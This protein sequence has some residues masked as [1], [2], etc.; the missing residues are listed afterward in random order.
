MK[1]IEDLKIWVR[2]TGA[3]WLLLI[4]AWSG[5][6][7]WEDYSNRDTALNQAREFARSIHEMTMAGLTGMMITGTVAQREVFLDQI[8]Q[9]SI[10]RDLVV[11]RGEAVTKQF[12]AGTRKTPPMDAIEQEVMQSG[13]P[14]SAVHQDSGGDYLRVVTPALASKDYLGKNCTNC[15]LVAEKTPLGIVSMN[16]SLDRFDAE[17]I[18]NRLKSIAIALLLSIPFA[19]VVH[20][21]IRHS[22]TV[23]LEHMTD[24]LRDIARGEGDLT[25]RLEAGSADEI[26]M[27]ASVFNEMMAKIAGLVRQVSGS[28]RQ[29]LEAARAL[30]D[31]AA[32]VTAGSQHQSARAAATASTVAEMVASIASVATS[33]E[34]VHE[35]SQ[36]SRN[37]SRQGTDSLSQLIG[38]V[39]VV[40]AAV[41]DM[42]QAMNQFVQSTEAITA[43]TRDVKGIAEQTNLL[44]LNAAIEAARAGEQGRGFAVV[45]DE[46]R[47]LA[48]KSAHS[49]SEIEAITQ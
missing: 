45:A 4:A 35:R 27:A 24:G 17:V 3:I 37:R 26:G 1:K 15:H 13:K 14:Y 18:A 47:K 10:V 8:K 34:Q 28:A 38:E 41:K 6:L 48:E 9:L 2:L 39:G 42:A 21:F 19:F 46:V 31:G 25:R 33:A 30:G 44:A 29:V 12:G 43:M 5:M 20:F 16:I 7:V 23:P 22:V 49:A 11:H 32:H 36:E 40:K